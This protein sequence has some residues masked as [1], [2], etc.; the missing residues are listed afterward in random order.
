MD[1]SQQ[2]AHIMYYLHVQDFVDAFIGP[3]PTTDAAQEHYRWTKEVR[4]D[5]AVM[6]GILTECPDVDAPG[7]CGI[8][9]TP[10]QD[11]AWDNDTP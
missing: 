5:G 9:L 10:E 3:F 11:K 6:M 4:G 7:M 2:H 1:A 8:V